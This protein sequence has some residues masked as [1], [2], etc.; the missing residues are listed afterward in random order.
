[1]NCTINTP[2]LAQKQLPLAYRKQRR[3]VPTF[4]T[5]SV[6]VCVSTTLIA[7]LFQHSQVK[8]WFHHLL[9][10]RCDRK[11]H[12]DI[13][14]IIL[15]ILNY[16]GNHFLRF[17]RTRERFRNAS[18]LKFLEIH[19]KIMKL[20]SAVFHELFVQQFEEDQHSLQTADHFALIASICS[21]SFGHSGPL[22]YSSLTYYNLAGNR[23]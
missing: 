23:E 8:P 6:S 20:W 19:T 12:R 7:V 17:V 9:P 10:L 18:C 11:I 21:P 16:E 5:Y 1:M 2:F 3:F 4:S 15:N 13:C 14:D 22:S